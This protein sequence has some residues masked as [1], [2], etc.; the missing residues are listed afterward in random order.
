[1]F[2]VWDHDV[3]LLLWSWYIQV[4]QN[5]SQGL[6]DAVHC[7]TISGCIPQGTE[8]RTETTSQRKIK[9]AIDDRS[10]ESSDSALLGI[11]A[12]H[13]GIVCANEFVGV[14]VI[15]L[16]RFELFGEATVK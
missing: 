14:L 11:L 6:Q 8:E 9:D 13:Y 16:N 2:V 1:M 7:N 4:L 12:L 5:T 10:Y 15:S 3:F